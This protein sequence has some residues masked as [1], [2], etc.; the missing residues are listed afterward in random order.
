[1]EA[2]LLRFIRHLRHHGLEVSPAESL[3]AMRVAAT[4]GYSDRSLLHAGLACSLAK[5]EEERIAFDQC[6]NRFFTLGERSEIVDETVAS[7]EGDSPSSSP[8][9]TDIP[10]MPG[11]S[12]EG[13]GSGGGGGSGLSMDALRAEVMQ[14][15]NEVG[16]EKMEYPTQRGVYR[17]RILD[18]LGDGEQRQAIA[19]L[20]DGSPD[21]QQQAQ[22]LSRLREARIEAVTE[23]IDRQLLLNNNAKGRNYQEELMRDSSIAAMDSYYRKRLPPLIRKLAKKLASRHRQRLHRA[24]RG[25]PDLGKTLRR[26]LA[27]GGVP[28]HRYFRNTRREKSEIYLLCDL[29]GSVSQWSEV[30]MLFVQAL[31]DVL[32]NARCF[33]FCGKSIEVSDIFRQYPE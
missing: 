22:W 2:T 29:S 13:E 26:N 32:P 3:D 23:V 9:D 18:A 28:F 16:L 21:D 6:F 10:S 19:G 17:R 4:L 1:M 11:D 20:A 12:A 24:K 14:A 15:A 7:E 8:D 31:A 5:S 27:Y 25:K 33:V 30:L